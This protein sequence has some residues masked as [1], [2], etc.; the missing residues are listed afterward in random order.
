MRFVISTIGTLGDALPFIHVA[1]ALR[2]R[3]H[4][5]TLLVNS[6]FQTLVE[7]HDIA[8]ES[9]GTTEE[10]NRVAHSED[11]YH[12]MR[13]VKEIS[14]QWILPGIER[15][16]QYLRR[17]PGN[18]ET[19][20]IGSPVTVGLRIA[21]EIYGL[22]LHTLILSPF[23]LPSVHVAPVSPGITLPS[24]APRSVKR[25]M[26]SA[27]DRML[28]GLL[29]PGINAIRSEQNLTAL[30]STVRSWWFSPESVI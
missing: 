20:L 5:T 29:K 2:R 24:W 9:L 25:V 11:F 13:G 14:R 18:G 7:S 26:Q 17:A 30:R 27:A 3:G 28:D 23:F 6:A 19:V 21:Q 22:P 1:A 16:L 8:F 15:T 10:Y 12:P 4:E